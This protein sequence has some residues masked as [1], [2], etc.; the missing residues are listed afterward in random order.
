MPINQYF[1]SMSVCKYTHIRIHV[2]INLQVI[3]WAT[4]SFVSVTAGM[5]GIMQNCL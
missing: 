1:S 5:H 4:P 3:M 2:S